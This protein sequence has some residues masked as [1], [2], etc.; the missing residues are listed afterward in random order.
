MPRNAFSA[1]AT[2]DGSAVGVPYADISAGVRYQSDRRGRVVTDT[3]SSFTVVDVG[4][5]LKINDKFS[6]NLN[7]TNLLDKR[8]FPFS[9]FAGAAPGEPR[10]LIVSLK[11]RL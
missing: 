8:Y 9:D 3:L 4:G 11:G 6:L 7:V 5:R 10:R 2:L 1:F